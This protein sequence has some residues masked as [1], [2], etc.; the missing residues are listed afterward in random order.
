MEDSAAGTWVDS[1][2]NDLVEAMP[3][4]PVQD[5][6]G[7]LSEMLSPWNLQIEPALDS[8]LR[9]FKPS[10]LL[11]SHPENQLHNANSS[12][13]R[14]LKRS[15]GR[16]THM[17]AKLEESD[18][19]TESQ[20]CQ[21]LQF[22]MG[23]SGV[24]SR[25]EEELATT[26]ETEFC[27]SH[28][29]KK[30]RELASTDTRTSSRGETTTDFRKVDGRTSSR[31]S[32]G[33]PITSMNL[34]EKDAA[35]LEAI[36]GRKDAGGLTLSLD[37]EGPNSNHAR[38]M[39]DQVQH[40]ADQSNNRN[41]HE[42]NSCAA[43]SSIQQHETMLP[44]SG[45]YRKSMEE[46]AKMMSMNLQQQ[47]DVSSS[48]EEGLQLLS[49]LLQ[50][51]EAV[52]ADNLEEANAI[53]PQL[54]ELSSP[55]GNPVQRVVA[56][57]TEGMA[58]RILNSCL[59]I[60]SPLPA[61]Q[62]FYN[63][64]I[65]SAFQVFNGICPFVKFSHF[66]ANQAILEAFEGHEQVHIIDCDIMQGLQW[67]ALFHILASRPE[68]P[69]HVRITGIGTSM[70]ALEATG[71]RLSD[72]ARTLRLPFEF[73]AVAERVGNLDPKSLKV[74]EGDALAVHW[75]QH[76]LY[77]VTGSDRRTLQLLQ[78]LD[79]RVVTI[80]E[81]DLSYGGSFLS[82]FLESLHYYSA[83]FDSMGASFNETSHERHVVEQQLLASEIKN[84]LAVGG[85]AR[86]GEVKFENWRD[87]MGQAGFR[88]VSL[89]GNAAT[90]AALLLNMFPCQGY[91]LVQHC[92]TL[93]LGWKEL[94]LYTA[95]AWS[96]PLRS[97]SSTPWKLHSPQTLISR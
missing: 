84:I 42:F 64:S 78:E 8:R 60:C 55:Y 38:N 82:R 72:F 51:A 32:N 44:P 48:D 53:I 61:I 25:S 93:K 70:E 3:N 57:F 7:I 59:G 20:R 94:S 49:L 76:A 83:L 13:S 69:P 23:M 95:S 77:D 11:E 30:R 79:P 6:L 33:D 71:T 40:L 43:P 22:D 14:Y 88:Q 68:G 87:A 28:D 29:A 24:R 45:I 27:Y 91:S 5:V 4:M 46:E 21:Y 56:Y 74:R 97:S 26:E 89:A 12:P 34:M 18:D 92:G 90:Q 50:C 19:T 2:V 85:P 67:P 37:F 63:H 58:A 86:T 62:L 31:R 9:S 10:E 17:A 35:A 73:Q 39:C 81:Q 15:R 65:S 80:V 16:S 1:M 96:S 66:T 36:C 52:S 41:H 75:L 47:M 54:N